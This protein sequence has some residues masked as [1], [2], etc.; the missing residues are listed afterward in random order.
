MLTDFLNWFKKEK[1]DINLSNIGVD[2]H[3]HL[4][5]GIDDGAQSESDSIVMIKALKELG[6]K[7]LIATPH[8]MSDTY[9]NTPEQILEGLQKLKNAC[10]ENNIQIDLVVAAEYYLDD[11][12]EK[13]IEEDN[14]LY[15]GNKYLLFELSYL[16]KPS[17]LLHVVAKMIDKGYQPV[18]AHPERYPFLVDDRLEQ[19]IELK[20]AGVLFQMNILSLLG[21]Y[22]PGAKNTVIK[23][24]DNNM[25]N[26]VGTDFHNIHQI[27]FFKKNITIKLLNKIINIPHLINSTL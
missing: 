20:N 9:R 22:S 7:K 5:S 6:Y 11:Y 25:I 16:N 17:N 8:I 4:I 12:F 18:L 19:Y 23:L 3:S 26:F 2:M 21:F 13:L 24:I 15:F 10:N 1:F 14:V 27:D